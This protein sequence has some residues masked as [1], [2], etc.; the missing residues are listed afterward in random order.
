MARGRR[1]EVVEQPTRPI[2]KNERFRSVAEKRMGQFMKISEN[3][4]NLAN[5]DTYHYSDGEAE[6]LIKIVRREAD[7]FEKA[8]E[9]GGGKKHVAV[10]DWPAG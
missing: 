3:L 6:T 7:R 2:D 8:F 5:R 10:I 4:R 9:I 1:L